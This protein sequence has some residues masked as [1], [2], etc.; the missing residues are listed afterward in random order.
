MKKQTTKFTKQ[1][2]E[3]IENRQL[4]IFASA[5]GAEMIC[6]YLFNWFRGSSGFVTTARWMTYILLVGFIVLTVLLKVKANKFAKQEQTARAEKYNNW[7]FV[8]L[9]AAISAF[10]IY[11]TEL[12]SF[13]PGIGISVATAINQVKPFFNNAIS[14]RISIVMILVAIY[15]IV[16]MTYYSV[17]SA[18]AKKASLNKGGK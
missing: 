14:F 6:L 13:I 17:I 11:P 15:T 5:L 18:Q 16:A 12:I 4:S 3:K 10:F 9:A 7:F 2:K 8:T 1:E